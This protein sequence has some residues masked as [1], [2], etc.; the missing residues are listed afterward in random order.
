MRET[1]RVS[2]VLPF[3]G[4]ESYNV[5]NGDL[6]G[7]GSVPEATAGAAEEGVDDCNKASCPWG[8]PL[9]PTG[10]QNFNTKQFPNSPPW[11]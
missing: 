2:L 3:Y 8:P 11:R 10:K 6:E 9:R 4:G 1:Q 7:A 5:T